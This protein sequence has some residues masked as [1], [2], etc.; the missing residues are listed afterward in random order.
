MAGIKIQFK[1]DGPTIEVSWPVVALLVWL[2]IY[3]IQVPL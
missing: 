1:K 2:A 3:A